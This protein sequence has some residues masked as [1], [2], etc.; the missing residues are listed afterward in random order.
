MS[1]QHQLE[2]E[3]LSPQDFLEN[4]LTVL[5]DRDENIR[6]L[7]WTGKLDSTMA[8]KLAQMDIQF[9]TWAVHQLIVMQANAG[10]PKEG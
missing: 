2:G 10:L 7:T 5:K 3:L 9:L 8:L 6:Q 4:W 1:D